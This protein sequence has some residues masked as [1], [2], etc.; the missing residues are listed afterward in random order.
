MDKQPNRIVVDVFSCGTELR[1]PL[2]E[3]IGYLQGQ[4]VSVPEQY[5]P[6]V[7]VSLGEDYDDLTKLTAYYSYVESEEQVEQRLENKAKQEV[8]Y[9]RHLARQERLQYERL[10]AKFGGK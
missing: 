8:A 1:M 5:R 2:E 6:S 7:R 3:F 10:K 9:Q 4:L